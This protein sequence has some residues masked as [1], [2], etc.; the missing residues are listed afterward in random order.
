[1][2]LAP[3][4]CRDAVLCTGSGTVMMAAARKLGFMH[5]SFNLTAGIRVDGPWHNQN[6]NN[7]HS[8]LKD[9]MRK[10]KNVATR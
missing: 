2:H 5:L 10:F 1:M 6:A 4:L 7:Y 9:W 8:R 3:I